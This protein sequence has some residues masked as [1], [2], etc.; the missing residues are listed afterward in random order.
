MRIVFTRP[1]LP[2]VNLFDQAT[3]IAHPRGLQNG[4]G[5]AQRL[6]TRRQKACR[7]G[8][9]K[10]KPRHDAAPLIT[11]Q[12]SQPS[13]DQKESE[14]GQPMR[15]LIRFHIEQNPRHHRDRHK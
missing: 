15:L 11:V 7:H 2:P 6:Q 8:T 4:G 14:R 12:P 13:R 5:N 3:A 9:D 1:I 10:H